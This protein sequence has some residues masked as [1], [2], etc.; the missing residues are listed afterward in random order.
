MRFSLRVPGKGTVTGVLY[1]FPFEQE[2]ETVPMDARQTH[3]SAPGGAQSAAAH[4]RQSP[5]PERELM[6]NS[7]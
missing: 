2:R 3:H 7:S 5:D 6:R 1:Y 4:E